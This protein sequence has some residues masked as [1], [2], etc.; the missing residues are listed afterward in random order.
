MRPVLLTLLPPIDRVVAAHGSSGEATTSIE[1]LRQAGFGRRML[2]VVAHDEATIDARALAA[3]LPAR[4]RDWADSGLLWGVLWAALTV[5]ATS[6]LEANASSLAWLLPI[7]GAALALHLRILATRMASRQH[8]D[9]PLVASAHERRIATDATTP[10]NH[11][12]VVVNAGRGE[13]A[14]ARE[15]LANRDF[16]IA[17]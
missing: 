8:E 13:V 5:T 6:L 16:G 2:A 9:I 7:G 10:H 4:Q 12:L 1:R 3:A 14:T 11:Y 17:V 15:V